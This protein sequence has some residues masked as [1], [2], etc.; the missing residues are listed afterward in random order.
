M[1]GIDIHHPH[2]LPMP[3]ARARIEEVARKLSE[4]FGMEYAWDGDQLRFERSGVNGRI[5]L[6]P[7]ALHV[8][9]KLGFLL[10]AM[11]GPIEGEIRRVLEE[12]FAA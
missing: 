1:A 2:S 6:A 8:T 12:K 5:E 11:H 9:A 7:D 3:E 4:R 10:S